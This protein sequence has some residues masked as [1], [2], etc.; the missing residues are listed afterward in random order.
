MSAVTQEQVKAKKN[1]LKRKT[2]ASWLVFFGVL[3]LVIVWLFPFWMAVANALKTQAEFIA[4]GPLSLPKNPTFSHI[5]K[6]WGDVNFPKKLINSI[7]VSTLAPLITI[8]LSFL[9]AYAIGIGKI[10][11]RTTILAIF[12]IALTIPQEAMVYPLYIAA[13]KLHLY[14]NLTSIIIIFGVLQSAF[15]TYLLS[16]VLSEF[17]EEILEAAKIDGASSMKILRTIVFP[18]LMPTLLVLATFLFI[19][20]W[21]EFLIPLVLLPSNDNQTVAL[22]MA[23]TTGQWTSDPTA[24]AAAALLG[25]LPSILFFLVFQRTLMRGV[26]MGSVK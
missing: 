14:D 19:W 17:P 2:P 8:V 23:Y 9:S 21:N 15:G 24:R 25:A 26:T 12:M 4:T 6:F 7:I 16:S 20:D 22:S 18:L 1:E 5:T 3:L 10:K 11:G 13:K